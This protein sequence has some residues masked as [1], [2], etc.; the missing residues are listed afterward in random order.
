MNYGRIFAWVIVTMNF[1]AAAGYAIR[2]DWRLSLYWFFAG[3]IGATVT[4]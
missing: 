4:W 3:A 2:H 1:C